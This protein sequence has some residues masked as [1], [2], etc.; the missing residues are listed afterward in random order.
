MDKYTTRANKGFDKKM[1]MIESGLLIAKLEED[2]L[3]LRNQSDK[4]LHKAD[5]KSMHIYF[6]LF[7]VIVYIEKFILQLK[8][9]ESN[10][11]KSGGRFIDSL[12]LL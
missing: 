12:T 10:V 11:I 7:E 6:R 9:E 5:E 3:T 4:L 8:R 1:V 2:R